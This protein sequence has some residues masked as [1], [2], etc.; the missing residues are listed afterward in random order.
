MAKYSTFKYSDEVYGLTANPTG[1]VTWIMQI[2]WD[3]DGVMDGTNEAVYM[4]DLTIERGERHYI[5]RSG[6]FEVPAEGT[7]SAVMDNSTGRYNPY[8]ASS[9]LYPNVKPGRLVIIDVKDNDNNITYR[10]FTGYV[11]DIR[12]ESD[13][14]MVRIEGVDGWG[15]L[16][17]AKVS[18]QNAF[19]NASLYRCIV[20]M[21]LAARVPLGAWQIDN[22]TQPVRV[23]FVKQD[24]AGS[25]LNNLA[26]A[27]LGWFFFDRYNRPTFYAR[28]HSTMTT[29]TIDQAQVQREIFSSQPWDLIGNYVTVVAHRVVKERISSIWSLPDPLYIANGDSE[30]ITA[31]YDPSTDITADY[32]A[33]TNINGTGTNLKGNFAVVTVGATGTSQTTFTIT[34]NSGS[35]G[36]LTELTMYGRKLADRP[37]E[38]VTEDA[39]SQADYGVRYFLHD[40]PY[41]QSRNYAASFSSTIEA[42]LD[43]IQRELTIRIEQRPA[44]QF[45]LDLRDKI[46]FTSTALG[47]DA[48]FSILGLRDEWQ[49][50]TGQMVIT[51]AYLS[52]VIYDNTS[53]TA[54]PI[55]EETPIPEV[56]P[57][58]PPEGSGSGSEEPPGG[59]EDPPDPGQAVAVA[60]TA[61]AVYVTPDFGEA[62]PTWTSKTYSGTS[63]V[64]FDV[65]IDRNKAIAI[66][67]GVIYLCTD[68][69]TVGGSTWNTVYTAATDF[70]GTSPH[71]YRVHWSPTVANTVFVLAGATNGTDSA[72]SDAWMLKSED[73]GSNWTQNL[74]KLEAG[75]ITPYTVVSGMAVNRKPGAGRVN[76]YVTHERKASVSVWGMAF[77][78][79]RGGGEDIVVGYDFRAAISMPSPE[80][81]YINAFQQTGVAPPAT[82]MY[83]VRNSALGAGDIVTVEGW[84]DAIFG[85]AEGVAWEYISGENGSMPDADDRVRSG[86]TSGSGTGTAVITS[87]V[88]YNLENT[89]MPKTFDVANNGVWLYVGFENSI[90]KSEDGGVNWFEAY[91]EDGAF[92]IC[93]DPQLSGMIYF[94]SDDGLLRYLTAGTPGTVPGLTETP[95]DVPL[96]LARQQNG[97]KLWTTTGGNVYM[98]NLGAWT[99]QDT[100]ITQA[101]SLRTYIGGAEQRLV[102]VDANTIQYSGDA[103]A[104]WED[105]TGSLTTLPGALTIHLLE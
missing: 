85:G 83:T 75:D 86:F 38:Y 68:L 89:S 19:I 105:K 57:D 59:G 14:G 15:R 97:G 13:V 70:T 28:N 22:D 7:F 6:N 98:R 21:L 34:N 96:R 11:L 60:T 17:G 81:A 78:Y 101:R 58:E 40:T 56:P 33:W 72:K 61:S 84:F 54:E 71:L 63:I 48:T 93:V 37:L 88:I 94:W 3:G 10:R 26:Q 42:F 16:K 65:S 55:D 46:A 52:P 23:F 31:T 9:P 4:T 44:Y 69:L 91:G 29:H 77:T 51:T 8:N 32:D 80:S 12:P 62:S 2:D 92:D 90:Y 104:T 53:I 99:T 67:D 82:G 64:D 103:G 76:S 24:D 18:V 95:L 35:N 27:G 74:I 41:L 36:Y 49:R 87:H 1:N 45:P 79:T 20:S 47:I 5:T 50:D 30:T 66:S 39:A 25:V 73:G 102:Y 43:D 100:Y